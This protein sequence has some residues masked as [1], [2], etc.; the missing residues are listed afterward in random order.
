M[1]SFWRIVNLQ[2]Y[3]TSESILF[4]CGF[5][6]V[7]SRLFLYCDLKAFVLLTW[8]R[9]FKAPTLVI[10]RASFSY[11]KIFEG[12]WYL[13]MNRRGQFVS[14]ES[15]QKRNVVNFDDNKR[16][17]IQRLK[18]PSFM[19]TDHVSMDIII[20]IAVYGMFCNETTW[21]L[22]EDVVITNSGVL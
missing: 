2:L 22:K 4:N 15:G 11:Q 18:C 14:N 12:I 20:N 10:F 5:L 13:A 16:L 1:A 19:F 7:Q 3:I 21:L 9:D 8:K 17:Q 6:N